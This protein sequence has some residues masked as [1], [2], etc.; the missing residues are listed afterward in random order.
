MHMTPIATYIC[1]ILRSIN[2]LGSSRN[3][4]RNEVRAVTA[5]PIPIY[6]SEDYVIPHGHCSYI[7]L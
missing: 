4:A 3:D 7:G 2:L 1:V 5:T 6:A